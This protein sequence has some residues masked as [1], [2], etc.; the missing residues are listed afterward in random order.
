MSL[1]YCTSATDT[2]GRELA[3]HGS[4]LF[5]I[6]CYEENIS[7]NSAPFEAVPWHWHEE[8][9]ALLVREGTAVVSA[10]F[11]KYTL[12]KGQGIFINSGVLHEVHMEKGSCCQTRSIVFHPRLVG[13]TV[14]SIIWQKY[15]QPLLQN[16]L[17]KSVYLDGFSPWHRDATRAIDEAWRSV[18]DEFEGY[19]F[20]A[21]N[22]LSS[23]VLLLKKHCVCSQST[24]SES[25]LRSTE[26]IKIML[27]FIHRHYAEELNTAL[28]ARSAM[29]SESECLRCFHAAIGTTP[30][31]YLRQF[32]IQKAAELLCLS[33]KKAGDIGA[34]CGFEDSSYFTKIFREIKGCTPGEYRRQ[35]VHPTRAK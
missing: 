14:D 2:Q 8:W 9:E 1:S 25:R 35:N 5:P 11:E 20:Y 3:E 31:Q 23:L 33:Q 28:I 34:E 29:I 13:G 6:A 16:T 19:E 12:K 30:I 32:R 10:E 15:L 18:A 26:R 27:Q 7:E 17:L 4:A 22:A 24:F 21:R